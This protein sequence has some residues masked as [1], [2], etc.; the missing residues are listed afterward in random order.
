[1]SV[2]Q[3]LPSLHRLGSACT[4]FR[5][6]FS[7]MQLERRF[8]HTIESTGLT[9]ATVSQQDNAQQCCSYSKT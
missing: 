7:K 3:A 1:M 9:Q 8:R 4:T 6:T 2:V 5:K